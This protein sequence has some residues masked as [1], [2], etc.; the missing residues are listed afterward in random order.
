MKKEVK[1]NLQRRLKIIEGQVRGLQK[2]VEEEQYCIDVITQAHAAREALSSVE[3]V[4]LEN[5]L[6]T[7]VID[8]MRNGEHSKATKEILSVYKVS[9]KK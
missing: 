2:M 6:S 7:H 5:H 4:M 3:D 8:Q 9:K 1:K